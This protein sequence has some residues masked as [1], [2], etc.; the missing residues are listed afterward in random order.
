MWF[1]VPEIQRALIAEVIPLASYSVYVQRAVGETKAQV[2]KAGV[3]HFDDSN[4]CRHLQVPVRRT[5]VQTD[6]E[7]ERWGDMSRHG[8]PSAYVLYR[9]AQLGRIL[10]VTR[11]DDP[12][13]DLPRHSGWLAEK[14]PRRVASIA[15]WSNIL[16]AVAVHSYRDVPAARSWRDLACFLRFADALS[17]CRAT[18]QGGTRRVFE[19]AWQIEGRWQGPCFRITYELTQE[20]KDVLRLKDQQ[21]TVRR[22]YR[23]FRNARPCDSPGVQVTRVQPDDDRICVKITAP[24]EQGPRPRVCE[25]LLRPFAGL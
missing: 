21:D 20:M 11:D 13:A 3:N 2:V 23:D 6:Q 9:L 4:L 8:F 19:T 18:R 22:A 5:K 25:L 14:E 15:V 7:K 1:G 10:G 24:D 16:H 17:E 12:V